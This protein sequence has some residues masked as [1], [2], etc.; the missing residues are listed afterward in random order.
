MTLLPPSFANSNALSKSSGYR[1]LR[2][3]PGGLGADTPPEGDKP[4]PYVVKPIYFKDE[5][6]TIKRL[7]LIFDTDA[8]RHEAVA[9]RTML[10]PS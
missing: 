8:P 4:M 3:I 1:R 2:L 6:V 7:Y 5:G 10:V 9:G